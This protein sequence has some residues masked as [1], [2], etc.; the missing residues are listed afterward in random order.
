LQQF[1]HD[2]VAAQEEEPGVALVVRRPLRVLRRVQVHVLLLKLEVRVPF[3]ERERIPDEGD[4]SVAEPDVVPEVRHV[5][6][7]LYLLVQH[8]VARA[9]ADPCEIRLVGGADGVGVIA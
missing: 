3:E 7:A 8:G 9:P 2:R 1:A 5:A 6:K 4:V